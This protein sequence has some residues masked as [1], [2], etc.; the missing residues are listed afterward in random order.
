[1]LERDDHFFQRIAE[2]RGY[3]LVAPVGYRVNGA[4]GTG[5]NPI[6]PQAT[7][8]T[9]LSEKDVM[10]SIAPSHRRSCTPTVSKCLNGVYRG[11]G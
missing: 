6:N 5:A 2:R 8:M 4:Y 11:L 1:M 9:E 10:N 7:R 3:I